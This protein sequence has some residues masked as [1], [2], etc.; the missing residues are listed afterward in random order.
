MRAGLRQVAPCCGGERIAFAR[1]V[2]V[3]LN[4][5]SRRRS[6]RASLEKPGEM[7]K[8]SI[9]IFVAFPAISLTIFARL[10]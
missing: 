10:L 2:S 9:A 7:G 3:T 4:R 6:S 5:Y 1:R 8:L